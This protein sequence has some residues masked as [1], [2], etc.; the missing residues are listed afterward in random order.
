APQAVD[1]EPGHPD[2]VAARVGLFDD[3]RGDDELDLAAVAQDREFE[4]PVEIE[5]D[6]PLDLF[7]PLDLGPVD[8]EDAVADLERGTLGGAAGQNAAYDR[9]RERLSDDAENTGEDDDREEE[10]RERSRRHHCGALA[11]PLVMEG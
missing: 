9:R 2:S 8:A 1:A 11:E 5:L 4:R 10:I 6:D 7:E 3:G